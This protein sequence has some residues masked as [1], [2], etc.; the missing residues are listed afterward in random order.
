MG[1]RRGIENRG[2]SIRIGFS[3]KGEYCKETLRLKPTERNLR[4]AERFRHEVLNQ[5]ERGT[6]DYAAYFPDSPRAIYSGP[7]H[8]LTMRKCLDRWLAHIKPT[9]STSTYRDYKNTVLHQ[10]IPGFG[11]YTVAKVTRG[12]VRDWVSGISAGNKRIANLV[13]PLRQT[14]E[15]AVDDGVIES[16]PLHDWRYRKKE[17][18]SEDVDPF[19]REEQSAIL[20]HMDEQGRNLIQFAFWTGMRTSE[21]VALEWSDIDW[22]RKVAFVTKSVTQASQAAEMPKTATSRRD[23]KLLPP[24]LDA[25][26]R[27]KDYTFVG[28]SR[29]FHNPRTSKPWTGDQAIRKTLWT[30]ALKRAGVRY[31]YPYQTR[32]TYASMMLSAGENPLWVAKQMGHRDWSMIARRY[33]K[34]L[35]DTEDDSGSKAV[36]LYTQTDPPLTEG[37]NN[38]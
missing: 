11:E 4:Y 12:M 32:H 36:E 29:V 23:V 24:A 17:L 16:N 13:S 6:F 34:W 35:P 14:L 37:Q 19:T 22:T 18:P 25:L 31:R 28:Q 3:Y 5:I 21:M 8:V 27:Q 38:G 10:L 26:T 15:L 2:T 33:G 20:A 9:V 7:G 30:H 1:K